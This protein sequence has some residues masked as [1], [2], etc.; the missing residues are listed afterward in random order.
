MSHPL[1]SVVIPT[2]NR[3]AHITC[4]INYVQN[5]S[6]RDIEIIVADDGSIDNTAELVYGLA[7]TDSRVRYVKNQANKGAQ[8]AR[9]L[10]I[11]S[12]IGEW[13]AFQDS[14]DEWFPNSLELRLAEAK[15][16]KV[17]VVH[18]ECLIKYA[19]TNQR[20]LYGVRPLSGN[21]YRDVLSAPGPV[22]PTL[23][24]HISAL[25]YI[26]YLDEAIVSFQEWDTCIRLA[27]EYEFGFVEKPT[28]VYHRHTDETISSDIA[29]GARGYAQIVEK[30]KEEIK[31]ILGRNVLAEH[32]TTIA[33]FY[34]SDIKANY[35]GQIRKYLALAMINYPSRRHTYHF[36]RSLL[37]R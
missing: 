4:A 6:F 8:S 30:H 9:N 16:R 23:L 33:K 32:Y 28:F 31:Y 17:N 21:I 35:A 18:S 22:F 15:N 36:L 7:A 1:V 37:N 2:Y 24:V 25:K 3:A 5:Q 34:A 10:G 13:V 20:S 27:K 19:A 11:K 12:A 14:D 29:R 26:D